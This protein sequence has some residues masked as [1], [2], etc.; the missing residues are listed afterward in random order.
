MKT[1]AAKEA[2]NGF[3]RLLDTA[4]REP[5]TIEKILNAKADE[6]QGGEKGQVTK[7]GTSHD[8]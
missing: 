3:G 8:R 1:F 7:I 2:K 5:V 4:W 6:G